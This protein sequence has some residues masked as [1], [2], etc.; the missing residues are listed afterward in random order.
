[1]K[2]LCAKCDWH[3]DC[4]MARVHKKVQ[5]RCYAPWPKT[6]NKVTGKMEP[7][8]MDCES[9]NNGKCMHFKLKW[10]IQVWNWIIND[11]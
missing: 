11:L 7:R 6:V 5:H 4:T 8:Y 10:Y 9:Q 1:M 3:S 2:T